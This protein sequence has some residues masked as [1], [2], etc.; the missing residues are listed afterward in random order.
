MQPRIDAAGVWEAVGIWVEAVALIAIF[1]LDYL[2]RKEARRERT[3]QRRV[4]EEEHLER[5]EL[6]EERKRL[7]Q[8]RQRAEVTCLGVRYIGIGLTEERTFQELWKLTNKQAGFAVDK[9]L[10]DQLPQYLLRKCEPHSRELER[11]DLGPGFN[12]P[13][14]VF[15]FP[16]PDFGAVLSDLRALRTDETVL[17]FAWDENGKKI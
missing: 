11:S 5:A 7:E 8:D 15:K 6:R 10:H 4:R 13:L 9:H 14:L 3:E 16:D 12:V 17:V 1:I 2:E